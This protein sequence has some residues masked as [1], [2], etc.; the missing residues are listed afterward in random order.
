MDGRIDFR[1]TRSIVARIPMAA[2]I[3]ARIE[4]GVIDIS[5]AQILSEDTPVSLKGSTGIVS[6][7]ERNCPT[8]CA[9]VTLLHGSG[10]P[11]RL[12]MAA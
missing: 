5:R 4:A 11:E 3:R 2:A 7:P 6:A 10:S 8:R 12:A 1:A 9:P